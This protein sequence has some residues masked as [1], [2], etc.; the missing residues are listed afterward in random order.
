M[1]CGVLSDRAISFRRCGFRA[2]LLPK[3]TTRHRQQP[4]HRAFLAIT[5]YSHLILESRNDDR[6]TYRGL[7]GSGSSRNFFT[8]YV[9]SDAYNVERFDFNKG[10]NS[11]MF[12]ESPPGGGATVYTKRA[13]Q[14]NLE[15]VFAS[16]GTFGVYRFQLD[17]NRRLT[18][19]LAIRFNAANR[20]NATYVRGTNDVFRAADLAVTYQPFRTTTV[21]MEFERGETHRLRSD[22]IGRAHV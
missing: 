1:P 8:W 22:K 12:G 4:D 11:M 2:Y 5:L 21:R 20:R 6:I 10:S 18:D 16:Y 13:R 9:P 15:E 14:R 7:S 19:T 17:V 3:H